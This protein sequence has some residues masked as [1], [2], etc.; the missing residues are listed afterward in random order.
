GFVLGPVTSW[1]DKGFERIAQEW[2]DDVEKLVT[3]CTTVQWVGTITVTHREEQSSEDSDAIRCGGGRKDCKTED[4]SE[5]V[6]TIREQWTLKP[7]APAGGQGGDSAF[8]AEYSL[9]A[10]HREHYYRFAELTASCRGDERGGMFDT[11]EETTED[12]SA[13]TSLEG[14]AAVSI[15]VGADGSLTISAVRP[16]ATRKSRA[17][18]P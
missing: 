5:Q 1:V 8:I 7:G 6:E 13:S 12:W 4:G 9:E 18:G 2:V 16:M 15:S 11:W 17:P 3:G 10:E 14:E